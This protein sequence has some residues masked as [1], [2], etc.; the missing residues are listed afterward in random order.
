[1]SLYHRNDSSGP[2]AKCDQVVWE[3]MAKAAEIIVGSRCPSSSSSGTSRFNLQLEEIPAVRAILQRS[4]SAL[5]VPLRL[6]V[7]YQHDEH[8]RELLER[9]CLSYA[10][11]GL[12]RFLHREA[13]VTSDPIVQLRHVCKRIVV[14]LRVLCCWSRLLAAQALQNR[15]AIGFS[16]YVEDTPDDL[17]GFLEQ[18]QPSSVV[19]PYGELGWK[20]WYADK[21]TIDRLRP[22]TSTVTFRTPAWP[23]PSSQKQPTRRHET[24]TLPQSAP[25][26]MAVAG[27]WQMTSAPR[28]S[29]MPAQHTYDPSRLHHRAQTSMESHLGGGGGG[30]GT[31]VLQRRHTDV[32]TDHNQDAPPERV[33]SGLSLAL[34]A[35]EQQS[36][37]ADKRRA[38]LHQVPPHLD[39]ATK[40]PTS[41]G[42]YGYA[43]NGHIPWQKIHPSSSKPIIGRSPSMDSDGRHSTPPVPLSSSP[44][45]LSST[46]PGAF[47]GLTPPK[48]GHLI[49]PRK[50]LAT[51]PF[52]SRPIG[53]SEASAVPP[54]DLPA[55]ANGDWMP[56]QQLDL[57]PSSPFQQSMVV[58]SPGMDSALHHSS[59]LK[60]SIWSSSQQPL[61][62][63]TAVDDEED[64]MPFAVDDD[65][66]VVA[67][68][69]SSLAAS[70]S[71]TSFAQ[72]LKQAPANRLKLFESQ[73]TDRT[74]SLAE[75]LADFKSFGA[76]LGPLTSGTTASDHG[77]I[78]LRT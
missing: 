69:S 21:D 63:H 29:P 53:L 60:R 9:W 57:L 26:H 24:E 27:D 32:M 48:L 43:Y 50:P 46:P 51:P 74:E 65:V 38:A 73:S 55:A 56:P 23:I 6:D 34:L 75:Q 16:L 61:S 31:P 72:K 71:V 58:D 54:M 12:E 19:T 47:A 78:S 64:E 4:R 18:N 76:S 35:E 68:G 11:S 70:A 10:P 14:W 15:T 17:P 7:Y 49:P 62:P 44:S 52:A 25:A 42:E 67:K 45:F 40:R 66:M 41:T 59:D 28:Q 3:A 33:L 37:S 36:P 2:R 13:S 22:Q 8:S 30:G 1:M 39:A 5:H 77:S 20:V